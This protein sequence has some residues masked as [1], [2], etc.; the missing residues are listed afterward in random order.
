LLDIKKNS[1]DNQNTSV[2]SSHVTEP[3]NK[4]E[5]LE[6]EVQPEILPEIEDREVRSITIN[7]GSASLG[8]TVSPDSLS[9]GLVIRSVIANGA[10]AKDGTLEAGDIITQ[11]QSW[12]IDQLILKQNNFV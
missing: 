4:P 8:I 9:R 5:I 11:E 2:E 7:K 3:D 12:I 1:I 6:P 10:V